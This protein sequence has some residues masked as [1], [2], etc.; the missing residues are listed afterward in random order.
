[1]VAKGI[2][3]GSPEAQAAARDDLARG[4]SDSFAG[5]LG[6]H[7]PSTVFAQHGIDLVAGLA[8]GITGSTATAT[9]AMMALTDLIVMIVEQAWQ[10]A[11]RATMDGL[12]AIWGAIGAQAP[13]IAGATQDLMTQIDA[14][15]EAGWQAAWQ[16]T[17]RG[18]QAI[19]G[20]IQN[21]AP[22]V[23]GAVQ[24]LMAQIG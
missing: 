12:T 20:A 10:D 17:M 24:Q 18:I 9:D 6:I 15:T 4:L 19:W 5:A 8:Q 1:G 21:R 11:W 3:D 22:D 14:A 16:S 2:R 7:S 23:V 13:A